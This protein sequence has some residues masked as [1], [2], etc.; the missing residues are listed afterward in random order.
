MLMLIL[1]WGVALAFVVYY[2]HRLRRTPDW[3]THNLPTKTELV[4][5]PL[6]VLV[7]VVGATAAIYPALSAID[8]TTR[9]QQRD[10][11][12]QIEQA[13]HDAVHLYSALLVEL[14]QATMTA[15]SL[16]AAIDNIDR[17][18]VLQS[19][20]SELFPDANPTDLEAGTTP[21]PPTPRRQ[22]TVDVGRQ[23]AVLG[24]RLRGAVELLTEIVLNDF[25]Y[26]CYLQKWETLR[27]NARVASI[28]HRI[29]LVDPLDQYSLMLAIG[30]LQLGIERTETVDELELLV[31]QYGAQRATYEIAASDDNPYVGFAMFLSVLIAHVP[32]DRSYM[33]LAI[34][35]DLVAALPNGDEVANCARTYYQG[36]ED[37][38]TLAA[39]H[40]VRFLPNNFAPQLTST[41]QAID[42]SE[43]CF[44]LPC[45]PPEDSA[46]LSVGDVGVDGHL[47]NSDDRHWYRF[48]VEETAPYIIQTEQVDGQEPIDT[49]IVLVDSNEREIGFD[50]DSGDGEYS[51]LRRELAPGEYHLRITP[52]GEAT[53]WYHISVVDF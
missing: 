21:P 37:L 29:Q 18:A 2:Y 38:A 34:L 39:N 45:Q 7:G 23:Q 43:F 13:T 51:L 22:R 11:R 36:D 1:L 33:G 42:N 16:R 50:D 52:Y 49:V 3:K 26:G 46:V 30:V 44:V 19:A 31:S 27:A 15:G 40:A 14:E 9:Q 12:R 8:L 35:G 28:Y 20:Q 32:D 53:G 4:F 48:I 6:P 24:N 47:A 17:D 25:A 5:A 41:L 10:L